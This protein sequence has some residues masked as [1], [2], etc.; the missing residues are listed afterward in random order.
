MAVIRDEIDHHYA[1]FNSWEQSSLNSCRCKGN[2]FSYYECRK[3]TQIGT[4]S[5]D[6]FSLTWL[7]GNSALLDNAFFFGMFL[8]ILLQ[9]RDSENW[10]TIVN[11]R[12]R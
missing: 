9:N 11:V 5:Q 7:S 2:F 4:R 1:L 3:N 10:I 12:H 8:F 6:V